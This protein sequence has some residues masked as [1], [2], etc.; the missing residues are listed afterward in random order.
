MTKGTIVDY[1]SLRGETWTA[2]ILTARDSGVADLDVQIPG[3]A[4]PL[5]LTKVWPGDKPGQ[6]R[7]P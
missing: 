3:T 2:V 5:T 6:W 1:T 4:Q 7:M